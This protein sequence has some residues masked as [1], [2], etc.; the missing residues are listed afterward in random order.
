[1]ERDIHREKMSVTVEKE[2][3]KEI[4][5]IDGRTCALV[6]GGVLGIV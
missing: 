5:D 3:R 4:E 6:K 1:M 2:G